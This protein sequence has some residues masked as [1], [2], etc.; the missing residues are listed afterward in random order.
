[1]LTVTVRCG[2]KLHHINFRDGQVV[3]DPLYRGLNAAFYRVMG[4]GRVCP[5]I[6]HRIE[7]GDYHSNLIP[8]RLRNTILAYVKE[9]QWDRAKRLVQGF[10]D[11]ATRRGLCLSG[12]VVRLSQDPPA[13]VFLAAWS[14]QVVAW[15]QEGVWSV[16]SQVVKWVAK[17]VDGQARGLWGT[18]ERCFVCQ[19]EPTTKDAA[20]CVAQIRLHAQSDQHTGNVVSTLWQVFYRTR[21]E[22]KAARAR[23][24]A[25]RKRPDEE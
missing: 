6:I 3:L 13:L 23:C 18:R 20:Q 12:P 4:S 25:A 2:G 21:E 10:R 11:E 22:R 1:M 14:Q 24:R 15:L 19:F 17:Q 16:D 8:L 9:P 7:S 5:E